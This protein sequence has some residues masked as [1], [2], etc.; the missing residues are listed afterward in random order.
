MPNRK[1]MCVFMV[2]LGA[3]SVGS[4]FLQAQTSSTAAVVGTVK[5]VSG[6]VIAGAQVTLLN[7]ATSAT[8]S[9]SSNEQGQ[10]SFPGVVPGAY[11]I[12]VV[13]EGFQTANVSG[14]QF[15]ASQAYTVDVPLQ[16]G[17]TNQTV[18]VS[19][20]ALQ[21]QTTD[22]QTGNTIENQELVSL[23]T[24]TR[25]TY[26]LLSLQP[27]SASVTNALAD[28]N[29]A[30][31]GGAAG[32][33]ADQNT[34]TLD[35]ININAEG[36]S[37]QSQKYPL[38]VPL[39][40]E[41]MAEFR[42]GISGPNA[43]FGH[44]TGA[45][46]SMSS[47]SGSNTYHGAAYW[48]V[49]N[50][51]FN[52]N[53]WDNELTGS[54]KGVDRDNRAGLAVG[55]PIQKDK[56]FFWGGFELRRFFQS[57]TN[58]ARIPSDA[59]RQG[60]ITVNTNAATPDA[61][62]VAST[63]GGKA[64]ETC[65]ISGYDPRGL[66][67][68][69]TVGAFWKLYPKTGAPGA[70]LPGIV[71]SVG[72]GVNTVGYQATFPT[73]RR[74]SDYFLKLDHDFKTNLHWFG[75]Y[76]YSTIS[77]GALTSGAFQYDITNQSGG[78]GN[79]LS[80]FVQQ[81]SAATSGLDY[82]IRPN[83]INSFRFGYVRNH[84]DIHD[85]NSS[86]IAANYNLPGT[87]SPG[88]PV[89]LYVGGSGV[90]S[91][92]SGLMNTPIGIDGQNA[93]QNHAYASEWE[94]KD[95]MNW[96]K[97]SH[98]FAFGVDIEYMRFHYQT[99]D[100]L[101]QINVFPS[102]L[103]EGDLLTNYV[104]TTDYPTSVT[105]SALTTWEQ[106]YSSALGMVETTNILG[107]RDGNLNPLPLGTSENFQGHQF[108]NYIYIQDSWRLKPTLT[109]NYGLG[110]GW[111]SPFKENEGKQM[112]LANHTAGDQ[113]ID[114]ATYI[115]TE[116][117]AAITGRPYSPTLAYVSNKTAGLNGGYWHTDWSDVGPRLSLA[118]NPKGGKTV[119]RGGYAMLYN[120]F[121]GNPI[122]TINGLG[123][124]QALT[125]TFPLCNVNGAGGPGCNIGGGVPTNA[126]VAPNAAT[127]AFRVG[128]DGTIP[129][130]TV[131]TASNDPNVFSG[132][133][134]G[135]GSNLN[136][137]LKM[138]RSH[139]IDFTVQRALP[140]H[141]IL[142]VGY[143]GRLGRRLSL[144]YNMA[145]VP[146]MFADPKTGQTLAQAFDAVANALRAGTAAP[147]QSWFEDEVPLIAGSSLCPKVSAVT[148]TSTACLASI[149]NGTLFTNGQISSLV[150]TGT[151]VIDTARVARGLAPLTTAPS[152]TTVANLVGS[153]D[154]GY[155]NYNGV[156]VTLRNQGWNGV[157]YDLNYTRAAAKDNGIGGQAG[158]GT[159]CNPFSPS[160]CYGYTGYDRTN[161]F[162]SSFRYD[163]PFAKKETGGV[164]RVIG[165]WYVSGI[166]V[167]ESGTPLNLTNN[168]S[169]GWGASRVNYIPT[170]AIGSIDTGFHP[171]SGG[172]NYFANPSAVA[173][174]FRPL[175]LSTDTTTGISTPMRGF[176]FRNLDARIGKN[177]TIRESI[178]AEFSVDLFNAF[179]HH[180]YADP[181]VNL[182]VPAS[183]GSVTS[184]A[185]PGN[186]VN[187]ARWIQ[188]GLELRF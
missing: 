154:A 108:N 133:S 121:G 159:I 109:L 57:Y 13:K 2:L 187:S 1:M 147:T 144:G 61:G 160:A 44:S 22:A 39:P 65:N 19:A 151:A 107:V 177:T 137:N 28:T 130:A 77:D 58:I 90:N 161:T 173:A 9:A 105:G 96:V 139:L 175:Q 8:R 112:V 59:L 101:G 122:I 54:P 12:S 51:A 117:A 169:Q 141:Q 124:V 120:R 35:G 140:G 15:D 21:L 156:F 48:F 119:I 125:N 79:L 37:G 73:P 36:T 29:Q 131:G 166:I 95:D 31:A 52:A 179:N 38:S 68:S 188:L 20:E 14:Q 45:Q 158:V 10:Y 134:A 55:G 46:V 186:R 113:L 149:S 100:N 168:N 43:S 102:A 40:V 111:V 115:A 86:T 110:Y 185:V 157:T 81:G 70:F 172:G 87:S 129:V 27:G 7:T 152:Q 80:H 118:W 142:E 71:S 50:N 53:T 167:I 181:S 30:N 82:V 148:G 17:T 103:V 25:D 89:S 60:F 11:T 47:K 78:N 23:P 33:L 56:T 182:A 135:P 178:H 85:V 64:A 42:V 76:Q 184:T 83:L 92:N 127:A 150:N 176:G 32:T 5:D 138:G 74:D 164:G 93:K 104:A 84:N 67:I 180:N 63:L 49:Q 116:Q 126:G 136:P 155:S 123:F 88:G 24:L 170:V 18:E 41:G 75:R 69:P 72:D 4:G 91:L 153:N 162:N 132:V 143:I 6:A 106:L 34:T 171:G 98:S 62:C 99:I 145:S 26:E 114:P 16:I 128:I 97:G 165:G 174:E 146:Y 163:L 94:F 66:G 183:F 3:L